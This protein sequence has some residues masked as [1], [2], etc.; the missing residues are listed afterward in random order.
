MC[1]RDLIGQKDLLQAICNLLYFTD[2]EGNGRRT[3]PKKPVN[4]P[5]KKP[6]NQNKCMVELLSEVDKYASFFT[7]R[8][9]VLSARYTQRWLVG[10]IT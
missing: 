7:S 5:S 6:V 3:N 2:Y 10:R 1:A 4:E 8:S 9:A